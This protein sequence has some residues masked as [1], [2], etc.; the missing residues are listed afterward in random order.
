MKRF[1]ARFTK[2]FE[3][4]RVMYRKGDTI[5]LEE[6][7]EYAPAFWIVRDDTRSTDMITNEYGVVFELVGV[8]E[9]AA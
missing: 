7:A 5:V 4:G 6:S 2:E 3:I 1:M 8:L 9:K